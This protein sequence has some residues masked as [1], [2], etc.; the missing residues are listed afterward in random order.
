VLT[1][2][3]QTSLEDVRDPTSPLFEIP[4]IQDGRM[5]PVDLR[6]YGLTPDLPKALDALVEQLH[7]PALPPPTTPEEPATS[8]GTG[9][10]TAGDPATT[11]LTTD[12]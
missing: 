8:T 12:G 7:A 10:E 6:D 2:D 1:P 5:F 3:A 9:A 11:G 4:A